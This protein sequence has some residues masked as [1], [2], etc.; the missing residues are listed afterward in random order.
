MKKDIRKYTNDC[1]FCQLRKTNNFQPTIPMQLYEPANYPFER[2][3]IDLTGPLIESNDNNKYILVVKDALT[4]WIHIRA[5]KNKENVTVKSAIENVL[6]E[7]NHK[8]EIAITDNGLEFRSKQLSTLFTLRNIKHIHTTTYNP[9]SNGLVE[10]QNR[11]LKDNISGDLD[12]DRRNWDANLKD[13][14]FAYNITVN[15]ATGF[16][17]Y[18][19]N[20]GRDYA[21]N[22]KPEQN[23]WIQRID[24]LR[25]KL[26]EVWKFINIDRE[27]MNKKRNEKAA[28]ELIY[29]GYQIGQF[30]YV[31][32][33]STRYYY[34]GRKRKAYPKKLEL[35]YKGPYY[36]TGAKGILF[37]LMINGK[38]T[39]IHAINMKPVN[40]IDEVNNDNNRKNNK[41]SN[42]IVDSS[43]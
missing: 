10:N 19:L 32:N 23:N 16:T 7:I 34:E 4:K 35:R 38:N 22:N 17:P 39:T 2:I 27:E 8:I 33:H 28:N 12:N 31:K 26:N 20:Y 25:E 6:D 30:A 9:R 13:I 40:D 5:I 41:I 18:F 1:R 21:E 29:R 24:Q 37:N 14:E 11:T 3:H 42:H 43:S 15:D 36:I